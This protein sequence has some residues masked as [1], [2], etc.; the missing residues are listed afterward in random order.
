MDKRWR[1]YFYCNNIEHR[2]RNDGQPEKIT[3]KM[4]EK[5]K[6][7]DENWKVCD[8][9]ITIGKRK[10]V[11]KE[12]IKDES[13]CLMCSGNEDVTN[14]NVIPPSLKPNVNKKIRLCK[15]CDRLLQQFHI[16]LFRNKYDKERKILMD[17][18]SV[19]RQKN[20]EFKQKYSKLLKRVESILNNR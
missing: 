2:M 8:Y 20:T 11:K 6:C 1:D 12:A 4:F 7:I 10:Y 5:K 16:D 9:L 3:C 13:L 15:E 18:V 17:E 19:L 14:K